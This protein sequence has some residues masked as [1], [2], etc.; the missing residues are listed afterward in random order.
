ME[1]LPLTGQLG[2]E[3]LGADIRSPEDFASI[4]NA[5]VAHGVVVLRDQ[6]CT[7]QEHLA[8]ARRFG[9]IDVSRFF[10]PVD[11]HPEIATVL[12]EK[13]H[14]EAIGESWHTDHSYDQAPA[15]G[16][17]LR[18]IELPPYG[19]DTLFVSMAAAYEALSSAMRTFL[20]RL[21]AI[22]SSR[23]AFGP[24]TTGTEASRTGRL[25]NAE[26]ATQ[27]SSHPVVIAHPLSGRYGLYVNPAFTT[28]IEQLGAAESRAILEM[29]FDHCKQPEFQCRVRWRAGDIAIWDNRATW[30]KAINDYQGHRRL[31]HRVTLEGV[32]LRPAMAA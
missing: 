25:G 28:H 19:G 31:M 17:I 7:P 3:I 14:R 8:F 13:D 23:H 5:L 24:T 2:A 22:H 18:A 4:R 10:R 1:I 15:M 12:K 20:S 6:N 27:D 11:G 32:A 26:A 21:T 29:L 9:P 16:S 30:H